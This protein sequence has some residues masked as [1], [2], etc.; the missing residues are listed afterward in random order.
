MFKVEYDEIEW[1]ILCMFIGK[2]KSRVT[3]GQGKGQ[4]SAVSETLEQWWN[5]VM[6]H[7][8]S[9][10]IISLSQALESTTTHSAHVFYE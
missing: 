2:F 3:K 5:F 1:R 7:L 9:Q 4:G 6:E 8:G 10:E